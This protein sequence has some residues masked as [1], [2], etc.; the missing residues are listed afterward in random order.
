MHDRRIDPDAH[1]N[2]ILRLASAVV[3]DAPAS[4]TYMCSYLGQM[5]L[6]LAAHIERGGSLPSLWQRTDESSFPRL[7]DGSF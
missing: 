4:A 5:V 1:L 3:E 7:S 6:E 2:R